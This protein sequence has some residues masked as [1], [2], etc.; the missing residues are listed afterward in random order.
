MSEIL[1]EPKQFLSQK[2][3]PYSYCIFMTIF[4]LE[5]SC[6]ETYFGFYGDATELGLH[7]MTEDCGFLSAYWQLAYQRQCSLNG[8]QMNK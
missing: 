1:S 3:D 5:L 4:S 6:G 7:L 2:Q 8:F